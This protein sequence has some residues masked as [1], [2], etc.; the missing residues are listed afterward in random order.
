[1]LRLAVS[2]SIRK[3]DWVQRRPGVIP[4]N[5][6]VILAVDQM[7]EF[8]MQNFFQI[9]LILS[10]PTDFQIQGVIGKIRDRIS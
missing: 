2:G 8:M 10:P 3:T 4:I 7:K 9:S 5:Q 1:M 6:P